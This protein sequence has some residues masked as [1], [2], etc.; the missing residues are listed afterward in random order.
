MIATVM[1]GKSKQSPHFFLPVFW[2]PKASFCRSFG[3]F[4]FPMTAY[5]DSHCLALPFSSAQGF[6]Q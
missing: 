2:L 4:S 1:T 5:L 3:F 6:R